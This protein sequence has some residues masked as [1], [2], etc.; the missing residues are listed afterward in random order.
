MEAFSTAHS[1]LLG[2]SLIPNLV[3]LKMMA[4]GAYVLGLEPA[5]FHVTGRSQERKR[6]T[7]QF[8]RSGEQRESR[9]ELTVNEAV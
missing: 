5:N 1:G 4:E 7:L 6:G 8:L 2:T 3:Q 9:V